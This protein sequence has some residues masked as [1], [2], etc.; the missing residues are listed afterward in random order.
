MITKIF[1]QPALK[2]AQAKTA[3]ERKECSILGMLRVLEEFET[4]S[5]KFGAS[6]TIDGLTKIDSALARLKQD[7]RTCG[8]NAESKTDMD[9]HMEDLLSACISWIADK[10][11]LL[12]A[13]REDSIRNLYWKTAWC[14]ASDLY[15]ALAKKCIS[16]NNSKGVPTSV[17]DPEDPTGT[18]GNPYAI[19]GEENYKWSL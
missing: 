9:S 19:D 16:A 18:C 6:R 5:V 7:W 11:I 15:A 13:S 2:A 3:K 12:G 17:F 1:I 8:A 14:Y 4:E 10:P